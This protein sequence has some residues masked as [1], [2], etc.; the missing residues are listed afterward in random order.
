MSKYLSQKSVSS[1]KK[2]LPRDLLL[3]RSEALNLKKQ[4]IWNAS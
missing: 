3:L 2:H 4:T 1:A